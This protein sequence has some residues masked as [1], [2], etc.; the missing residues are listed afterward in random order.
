MKK[1][2]V[3]KAVH[4][5][6]IKE[7]KSHQEV[8]DGLKGE[9]V[10][11][12]DYLADEIAKIPSLKKQ[13]ENQNWVNLYIAVLALVIVFRGLSIIGLT[14][15]DKIPA[16]LIVLMIAIV[17]IIP[18][19]GIY[20]ALTRK[21]ETY[22]VVSII[23]IVSIVRALPTLAKGVDF[24][25]L[26]LVGFIPLVAAISLGFYVPSRLLMTYRKNR[27]KVEHEGRI[28][29]KYEY[30]FESDGLISNDNLLDT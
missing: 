14:M 29:G 27:V 25:F 2:Q 4:T 9:C 26:N 30:E 8:F 1:R 28:T 19:M 5:G 11:D 12:L 20:G 13:K 16:N 21:T 7:N 17:V 10:D 6:L 23:L 15:S 22:K 18:I 3:K 24:D